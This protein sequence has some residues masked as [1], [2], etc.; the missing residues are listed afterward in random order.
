MMDP[1]VTVSTVTCPACGAKQQEEM[2]LL[3]CE[4]VHSCVACGTI[5]RPKPGD[6]CVY[7]SYGTVPCPPAQRAWHAWQRDEERDE[8]R[9][10]QVAAPVSL[11]TT[12]TCPAC[13]DRRTVR[14]EPVGRRMVWVCPACRA[15]LYPPPSAHCVY[16]AYGSVPCPR[17]QGQSGLPDEG[18]REEAR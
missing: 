1:I 11:Q 14:M 9:E 17:Q 13:G 7:C 3:H 8:E 18:D 6:C 2:P 16:C 10:E 15:T 12:I 4:R 5:V